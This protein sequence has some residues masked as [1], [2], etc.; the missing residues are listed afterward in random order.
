[1]E[2][3]PRRLR[4]LLAVSRRGGIIA[5]AE[6]LGVSASAVSQQLA[7]LEQ[8]TGRQL[9]RR[10]TRG[11]QLT[12]DGQLL[13]E[14]AEEVE[15]VLNHAAARLASPDGELAGTVRVGGFESI[16]RTVLVP[17]LPHWKVRYPGLDVVVT[18]ADHDDLVR[19]LRAGR[20]DAVVLESDVEDGP[21]ERSTSGPAALPPGLREDHLLDDPWVIVAP[22]GA[23]MTTDVESLRGLEVPWLGVS[24][25]PASERAIARVRRG[26]GA[27]GGTKHA[28]YGLQTALALV[29]AGEG[30][31][32]APALALRGV[33]PPGVVAVHAEDLGVRRIVVRHYER[34]TRRGQAA[35]SIVTLLLEA[36]A[37]LLHDDGAGAS[38]GLSQGGPTTGA[39]PAL[40]PLGGVAHP[41][42]S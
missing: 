27:R 9:V 28:Y 24:D 36:V 10:T 30:I 6:A 22:V 2:I 39:F 4:Y 3:D 17:S 29:A 38:S 1:M 13:A 42:A 11:T 32:L 37:G 7:R 21:T 18:E 16:L 35:A 33:L 14:T 34:R 23:L 26:L 20:L 15:R 5:A 19:A 40:A 8:E 41:G 31:A 12:D 25:S